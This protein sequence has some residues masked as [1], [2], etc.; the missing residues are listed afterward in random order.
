MCVGRNAM[1]LEFIPLL[2][3]QLELYTLPRGQERFQ[4]YIEVVRGGAEP[5]VAMNPMG[6]AHCNALLEQ[7]LALD[8]ERRAQDVLAAF[9]TDAALKVS[10]VL[11]DD[12]LGGW[13]SRTDYEYKAQT[14]LGVAL[15]RSAWL[16]VML[17]TSELPSV[18]A[19]CTATQRTVR[20]ALHVIAHGDPRTLR[21][22]LKQ[23]GLPPEPRQI[24]FL[25]TPTENMP[26]LVAALFGD[27]AAA[28]FGYP[29]LPV[30]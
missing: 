17:W 19:V 5:L 15:R 1:P 18:E 6:K 12:A 8:A 27:A 14:Q 26:V 29:P 4:R 21:D 2:Q 23:E 24:P 25:E 16:T 22:V 30:G 3:K 20:R 7:Y 13:T 28:E 11:V 10:L 9:T